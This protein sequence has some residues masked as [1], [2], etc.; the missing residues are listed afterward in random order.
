MA[1]FR[2]H[3]WAHTHRENRS[4]DLMSLQKASILMIGVGLFN[5][6]EKIV[7]LKLNLN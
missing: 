4:K 2:Q 6:A 5:L 7:N 3:I 1:K